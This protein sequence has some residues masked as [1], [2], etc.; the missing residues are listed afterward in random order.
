MVSRW[1]TCWPS[2][3]NIFTALVVNPVVGRAVTAV[4]IGGGTQLLHKV[5]NQARAPVYPEVGL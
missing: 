1:P 4:L 2:E 3:I 5:I